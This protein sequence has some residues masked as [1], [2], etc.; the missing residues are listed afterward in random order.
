MDGPDHRDHSEYLPSGTSAGRRGDEFDALADLFLGDEPLGPRGVPEPRSTGTDPAPVRTPR[1]RTE[2][3]VRP[4][5]EAIVLGHLPVRASIWVRQYA[6]S[7]ADAVQ[8][9]VALLRVSP[10][11][12]SLEIVG[13][14]THRVTEHDAI[15][16]AIRDAR[17]RC[18]HW[19]VRVDETEEPTLIARDDIA[20]ITV[21]TGA[22][23]AAIVASYRLMK[24]LASDR[25]RR[26]HDDEGPELRLAIMGSEHEQAMAAGEK[27]E[28]AARAFL[29]RP[30]Q[31]SARV[32]RIGATGS[33][34]L[35]RGACELGIETM[36]G[37]VQG[38]PVEP[39]TPNLRLAADETS[40][41]P[42][43]VVR[44]TKATPP[45]RP[46]STATTAHGEVCLSAL[47]PGL[48]RLETRC[49][50]AGRVELAADDEGRLHLIARSGAD[51]S[52]P[53]DTLV[54]T[55][56]WARE[57]LALLLRAEPMLSPPSAERGS[58]TDP[59]LHLVT[60]EPKLI[61]PLLDADVR[62]HLLTE[63]EVAGQTARVTTELN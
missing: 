5:I 6:G 39:A 11:M 49:P 18:A 16:E 12:T 28:R 4:R 17:S 29:S 58:D 9:P 13:A 42:E 19:V 60:T 35:F 57:H 26:L 27:L 56:A 14:G 30:V 52:Q 55:S 25:D 51:P 22:D 34:T 45:P 21:L 23:E 46:E 20:E 1:V 37:L 8:A 7:V 48:T 50:K 62:V 24:S 33:A 31:V 40:N 47:I 44:P 2:T 41:E 38:G 15:E 53:V 63:I 43:V 61:R 3:A 59:V 32:P 36:L 54:A 10:E